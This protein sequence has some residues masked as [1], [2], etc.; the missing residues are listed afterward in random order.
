MRIK[1]KAGEI[2][3]SDF[4]LYYNAIVIKTARHW[5]ENRRADQWNRTQSS[6]VNPRLY[7]QLTTEEP[8]IHDG[9]R[10]VSLVNGVGK[11]GPPVLHYTQKSTPNV[12][13]T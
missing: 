3:M 9:E 11:T 13:K 6:A 12:L 5:H 1:N 4:R 2:A 10:T 8:P 7:A